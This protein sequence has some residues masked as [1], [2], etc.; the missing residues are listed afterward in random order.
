MVCFI[1]SLFRRFLMFDVPFDKD[2]QIIM[3]CEILFEPG[4]T[5]A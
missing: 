1:S 5:T 2:A 3:R 4:I